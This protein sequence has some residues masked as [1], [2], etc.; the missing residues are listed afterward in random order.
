MKKTILTLVCMM[1]LS[2]A[3]AST[4]TVRGDGITVTVSCDCSGKEACA[5]AL[6][7]Y[8]SIMK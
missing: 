4:C 3:F 8:K 6:E 1:A 5:R 7:K 2:S